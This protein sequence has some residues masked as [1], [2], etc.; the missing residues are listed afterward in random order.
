MSFCVYANGCQVPASGLFLHGKG[1]EMGD[2]PLVFLFPL[3]FLS[4]PP[5]EPFSPYFFCDE[6]FRRRGFAP[7]PLSLPDEDEEDRSSKS[8]SD[9]FLPFPQ[10]PPYPRR[11]QAL[12]RREKESRLID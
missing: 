2:R 12:S 5:I 6:P 7:P 1:T 9:S 10:I 3:F 4:R 11:C 8:R